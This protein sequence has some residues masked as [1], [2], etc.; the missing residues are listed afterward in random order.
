MDYNTVNPD[1]TATLRIDSAKG[2]RHFIGNNDVR[3][4]AMYLSHVTW[5]MFAAGCWKKRD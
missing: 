2:R 4:T 5:T 1:V 3:V